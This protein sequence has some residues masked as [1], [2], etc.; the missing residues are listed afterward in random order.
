MPLAWY[1]QSLHKYR[2]IEIPALKAPLRLAH[3][4]G[5]IPLELIMHMTESPQDFEAVWQNNAGS[6]TLLDSP[7]R[8]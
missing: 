8:K 2:S 4:V 6:A 7:R 1:G 5:S 3:T